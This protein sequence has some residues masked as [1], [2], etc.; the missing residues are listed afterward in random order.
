MTRPPSGSPWPPTAPD[1]DGS[2]GEDL[3]SLERELGQFFAAP[4][5]PA[6]RSRII[7]RSNGY[8]R[9]LAPTQSAGAGQPVDSAG[10]PN[11]E[12]EPVRIA[13][14]TPVIALPG[15]AADRSSQPDRRP[16]AP[17]GIR[18]VGRDSLRLVASLALVV[19]VAV[20]AFAVYGGLPDGGG[21][22]PRFQGAGA[23]TATEAADARATDPVSG[24]TDDGTAY[25]RVPYGD[26]TG[27]D[28]MTFDDAM[29]V[30]VGD[31]YPFEGFP[32]PVEIATY[33]ANANSTAQWAFSTLP[34]GRPVDPE[35]I[36][37]VVQTYGLYRG[38]EDTKL[39]QTRTLTPEG[40]ARDVY[41]TPSHYLINDVQPDGGRLVALWFDEQG[42]QTNDADHFGKLTETY[43]YDFRLL[44]S[45]KVVAFKSGG[46]VPGNPDALPTFYEN[47]GYVLFA[48][49]DGQWLID[50]QF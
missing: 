12:E 7:A 24:T 25:V 40:F 42:E 9:D 29:Q 5:P 37:A 45:G 4:T 26:C 35:T 36:A 23:G 50:E 41:L 10:R 14:P 3:A 13:A 20:S 1:G 17:R 2:D 30:I 47:A 16:P 22:P 18:R 33:R 28:P 32:P 34:T 8:R 43:L 49:R 27:V 15:Q 11:P 46:G 21:Q 31:D 48:E 6:L 39:R 44:P 19:L 38:C